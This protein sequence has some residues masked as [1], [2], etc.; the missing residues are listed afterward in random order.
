MLNKIYAPAIA[1]VLW[2]CMGVGCKEPP[3]PNDTTPD[4]GKPARVEAITN[5]PLNP[6]T[7]SDGTCCAQ[8]G[9]YFKMA[10]TC[11][12][13]TVLLDKYYTVQFN[14]LVPTQ[15][16]EEKRETARVCPLTLATADKVLQA[17]PNKEKV[18]CRV[19]G[20][21]YTRDKTVTVT[22]I[23]LSGLLAIDKIAALE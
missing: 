11:E 21:I 1:G 7:C 10:E 2:M 6:K 5:P 23:P 17:H 19:W 14:R 12:G 4:V 20:R 16:D 22:G 18:K 15:R 9:E 13:D 8:G 3:S